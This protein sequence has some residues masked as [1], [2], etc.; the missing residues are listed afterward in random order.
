MEYA[1][2]DHTPRAPKFIIMMWYD[3]EG[4]PSSA[5]TYSMYHPVQL[6]ATEHAKKLE[7]AKQPPTA[8][9]FLFSQFNSNLI[10]L[11]EPMGWRG[12]KKP[13][14]SYFSFFATYFGS[15]S[16]CPF[17][18]IKQKRSLWFSIIVT[19]VMRRYD[20]NFAGMV[21]VSTES[22]KCRA[23]NTDL[24]THTLLLQQTQLQHT[25]YQHTLPKS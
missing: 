1:V 22:R 5:N 13:N 2:V 21:G 20:G 19:V 15:D 23:K 4:D 25:H 18:R 6:R 7:A 16:T 17:L 3:S 12:F 9:T 8:S 14:L 10:W 11:F 24:S